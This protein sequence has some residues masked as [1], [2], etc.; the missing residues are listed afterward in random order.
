MSTT[1]LNLNRQELSLG[2]RRRNTSLC[3]WH[4]QQSVQ[5]NFEK[6][7]AAILRRGHL[8]LIA[9]VPD[10]SILVSVFHELLSEQS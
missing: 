7:S 9:C 4:P 6:R 10:N 1:V 3:G 8:R 5:N 2:S